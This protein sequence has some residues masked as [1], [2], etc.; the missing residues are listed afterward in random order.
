MRPLLVSLAVLGVILTGCRKSQP[1]VVP[2]PTTGTTAPPPAPA[3]PPPPPATDSRAACEAAVTSAV[4]DLSRRVHFDTDRYDI[5]PGDAAILDAKATL[6]QTHQAVRLRLTGH[7]DERYTD[8]YNFVLGTRRA[9]SA[10]DYLV[11]RGIAA[12]R[13]E[14]ASMGETQPLDPRSNEEAWALNRRVE[15]LLLSG[16]ETIASRISACQ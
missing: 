11:R 6:L 4:N 8:E 16:R 3:P 9:E 7:A 12:N 15:F 5:R 13:L 1:E 14:T 10:K 2:P